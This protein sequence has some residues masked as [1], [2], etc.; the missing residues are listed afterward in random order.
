MVII[1][2]KNFKRVLTHFYRDMN[3]RGFRYLTMDIR[4]LEDLYNSR[5]DYRDHKYDGKIVFT[6][7][8]IRRF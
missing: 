7:R 5:I 8:T 2:K 6:R 4:N 1:T 3:Y